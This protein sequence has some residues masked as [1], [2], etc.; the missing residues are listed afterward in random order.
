[1]IYQKFMREKTVY[2]HSTSTVS[3]FCQ[4]ITVHV[5]LFYCTL[6]HWSTISAPILKL[7]TLNG[8]YTWGT[9][10]RTGNINTH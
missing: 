5:F 4:I 8:W 6:S 3:N 9:L 10:I 2:S 7:I 1:M